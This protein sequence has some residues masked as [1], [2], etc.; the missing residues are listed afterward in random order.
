MKKILF[1]LMALLV[2]MTLFAERI[3]PDDAALVANNFMNV[4]S[5]SGA[6][7]AVPQKKMV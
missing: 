5:A 2:S 4:A 1:G 3:T 7:K 6:K